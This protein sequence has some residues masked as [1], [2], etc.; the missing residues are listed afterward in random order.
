MSFWRYLPPSGPGRPDEETI[1]SMLRD[2][3]ADLRSYPGAVPVLAPLGDI[4]ATARSVKIKTI[5]PNGP[6]CPPR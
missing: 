4:P 6:R 3:H 2:L 5:M 1:G